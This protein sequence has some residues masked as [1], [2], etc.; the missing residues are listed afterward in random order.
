M[1]QR[2]EVKKKLVRFDWAIKKIL[3]QKPNFKVLEGFIP[4]ILNQKIKIR[5]TLES[6]SNKDFELQK[7]NR[8]DILCLDEILEIKKAAKT[9]R[10]SPRDGHFWVQYS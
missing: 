3:R 8:V 9:H 4:C 7:Y 6:E 10:F 5:Q 1:Q 2:F